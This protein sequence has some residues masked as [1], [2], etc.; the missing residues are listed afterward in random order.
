MGMVISFEE[1]R[2]RRWRPPTPL[3]EFGAAF[4]QLLEAVDLIDMA[5]RSAAMKAARQ[6]VCDACEKLLV[7]EQRFYEG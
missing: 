4:E 5:P 3:E 2:A 7:R 6:A 1:A